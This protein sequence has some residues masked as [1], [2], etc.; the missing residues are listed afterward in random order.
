MNIV[1][2]LK[3][4]D[5][6]AKTPSSN[7]LTQI[8]PRNLPKVWL[9]TEDTVLQNEPEQFSVLSPAEK[10]ESKKGTLKFSHSLKRNEAARTLGV[11]PPLS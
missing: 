9:K 7:E 1:G 6:R 11:P 3:A 4:F 2:L 5:Y 8:V 10:C